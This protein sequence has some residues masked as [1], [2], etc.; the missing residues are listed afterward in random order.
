MKHT[1][2][3]LLILMFAQHSHGQVFLCTDMNG[4]QNYTDSPC[5]DT[6]SKGTT[7]I[8]KTQTTSLKTINLPAS[9]SV[10]KPK[11]KKAN[12]PFFSSHELRN[13]RVKGLYKKG[14]SM[15]HIEKRFGT[16]HHTDAISDIKERWFY[17]EP[18]MERQFKFKHGC[19]T[20]WKEKVI[21]QKLRAR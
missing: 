17:N 18:K 12:C 1:T 16:P 7:Y 14:L 21:V 4:K 8:P 10:K 19:L 3:I 20:S 2:F 9:L 5:A 11:I 6:Q 13:M 15:I